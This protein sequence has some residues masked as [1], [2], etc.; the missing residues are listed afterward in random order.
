M[1]RS[2]ETERQGGV[3]NYNHIYY[4]KAPESVIFSGL[5]V[6]AH[7]LR[8]DSELKTLFQTAT[9]STQKFE[10]TRSKAE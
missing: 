3:Y 4:G 5:E 8:D 2:F 10:K 9:N 1:E 7:A 6:I